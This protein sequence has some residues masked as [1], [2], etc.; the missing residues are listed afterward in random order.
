MWPF[1]YSFQKK[2]SLNVIYLIFDVLVF[3][4]YFK[5]QKESHVAIN[6]SQK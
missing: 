1:Y 3:T 2:N 5:K 4:Y 6:N